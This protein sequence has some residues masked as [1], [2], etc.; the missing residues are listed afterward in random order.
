MSNG[1]GGANSERR[2]PGRY[3]SALGARAIDGDRPRGVPN[4]G[5]PAKS[6]VRWYDSIGRTPFASASCQKS[7]IMFE[8]VGVMLRGRAFE[9]AVG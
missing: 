7:A 9:V 5:L 2:R 1:N 6:P 4:E 3:P 8:L